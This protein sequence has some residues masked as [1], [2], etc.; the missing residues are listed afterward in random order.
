MR[1]NPSP[2]HHAQGSTSS[3]M[4]TAPLQMRL[5]LPRGLQLRS[6]IGRFPTS[7]RSYSSRS[8]L[9]GSNGVQ[10]ASMTTTTPTMT[11]L[12]SWQLQSGSPSMPATSQMLPFQ[13]DE[14]PDNWP[15]GSDAS[16]MGELYSTPRTMGL[17]I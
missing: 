12:V 7:S 10:P 5:R 15:S 11:T 16:P 8:R 17:G 4:T 2:F 1:R 13:P 14:T 9:P 3:A 6:R